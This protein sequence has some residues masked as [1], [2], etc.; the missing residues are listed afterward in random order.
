MELLARVNLVAQ[1]DGRFIAQICR[2]EALMR[3]AEGQAIWVSKR[4]IL[5]LPGARAGGVET[6]CNLRHPEAPRAKHY[7][8]TSG[9]AGRG[10]A[11]GGRTL[12]IA[13]GL[14]SAGHSRQQLRL[15]PK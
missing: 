11:R 2:S 6:R 9:D 4:T 8:S 15:Q 3:L 12:H 7:D 13:L 5:M 14:Q 10:W 1:S